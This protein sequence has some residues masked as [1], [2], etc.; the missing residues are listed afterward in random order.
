MPTYRIASALTVDQLPTGVDG[1]FELCP[2]LVVRR[3]DRLLRRLRA[4]LL[5]RP[6]STVHRAARARLRLVL[7][8]VRAGRGRGQSPVHLRRAA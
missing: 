3:P 6:G 5:A 1:T 8:A 4:D 2:G 7:R